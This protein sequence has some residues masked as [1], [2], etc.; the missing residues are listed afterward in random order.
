MTDPFDPDATTVFGRVDGPGDKDD[1]ATPAAGAGSVGNPDEELTQLVGRDDVQSP[2]VKPP[3][4]TPPVGSANE[5]SAPQPSQQ[6]AQEAAAD[7]AEDGPRRALGG[8]ET[9]LFTSIP[10][11]A[12]GDPWVEPQ[13]VSD[14]ATPGLTTR[15]VAG[16]EK[17]LGR[18]SAMMAVGTL[19]S[20][21]LGI[22]RNMLCV[23]CIGATTHV[24]R[25]QHRQ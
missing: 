14:A 24:G 23:A 11:D 19:G 18:N 21:V 4:N 17:S 13:E 22:V 6:P 12:N 3:H 25:L 15:D 16:Q 2:L 5:G 20:R 1:P 9:L 10:A 7:S 8:D